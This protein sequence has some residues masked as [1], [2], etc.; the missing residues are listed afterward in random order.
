MLTLA[1]GFF[2]SDQWTIFTQW[3]FSSDVT[4]RVGSWNATVFQVVNHTNIRYY[5]CARRA[6]G[7]II[8]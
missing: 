3:P 2:V 8:S 1:T 7:H 4:F 5:H 6:A